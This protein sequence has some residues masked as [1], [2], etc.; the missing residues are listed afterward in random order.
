MFEKTQRN[1][2]ALARSQNSLIL[3]RVLPVENT[4][5]RYKKTALYSKIPWELSLLKNLHRFLHKIKNKG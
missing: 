4:V 2:Y 3:I 5:Q 1:K